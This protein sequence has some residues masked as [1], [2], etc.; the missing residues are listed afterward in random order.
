[1]CAAFPFSFYACRST[2]YPE[3]GQPPF[4]YGV[5]SH[6][7]DNILYHKKWFD[8]KLSPRHT[9][10]PICDQSRPI[11]TNRRARAKPSA[12]RRLAKPDAVPM[13]RN[14]VRG[15]SPAKKIFF[16]RS[17]FIKKSAFRKGQPMLS[18][19]LN[20]HRQI[21]DL[22]PFGLV[23]HYTH[24]SWYS[25]IGLGLVAFNS[26]V[27]QTEHGARNGALGEA[28]GI[29]MTRPASANRTARGGRGKVTRGEQSW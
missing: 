10:G 2:G 24:W 7:W 26:T 13:K 4:C 21:V 16:V 18:L 29:E 28:K 23:A 11:A 22:L 9:E 25:F 12:F 5:I 20:N 3:A 19:S 1:M 14:G 27:L 17:N 6:A 15:G 8:G